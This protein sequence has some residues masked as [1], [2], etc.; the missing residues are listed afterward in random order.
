[1]MSNNKRYKMTNNER[2]FKHLFD[3]ISYDVKWWMD[4]GYSFE[5]AFSIATENT[6]AGKVV[7]D[8]VKAHFNK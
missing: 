1:M 3:R 5:D 7:L 8:A 2:A 6:W 4:N